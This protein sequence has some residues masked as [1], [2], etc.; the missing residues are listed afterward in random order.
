[1]I[2]TYGYTLLHDRRRG[3]EKE[4][5]GGVGIAIK[6]SM[7][8]KHLKGRAFSSFEYSMISVKLTNNTK[9][10]LVSIYRWLSIAGGVFISEFTELLEMLSVRAE[11]FILTGDVNFHMETDDNHAKTLCHLWKSFNLT[12]HI[13]LPT[14]NMGHT[15]DI[16][17][18][19]LPG[20]LKA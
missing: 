14:H 2:K 7:M 10:I 18:K 8:G 19:S 20:H 12:Q 9:L 1:M 3:R 15:L 13:N 5:G 16:V 6:T 11:E 4:V 17:L